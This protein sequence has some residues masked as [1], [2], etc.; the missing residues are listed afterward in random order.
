MIVKVLLALA[1]LCDWLSDWL[2]DI[3]AWM[4]RMGQRLKGG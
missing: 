4:T 1:D 2:F 3:G